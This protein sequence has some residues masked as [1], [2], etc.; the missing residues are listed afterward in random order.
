MVSISAV[1]LFLL[2]LSTPLLFCVHDLVDSHVIFGIQLI[3]QLLFQ[4]L[5]DGLPF[6]GADRGFNS[7]SS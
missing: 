4:L 2:F 5:H 3:A 6:L 7:V 1:F